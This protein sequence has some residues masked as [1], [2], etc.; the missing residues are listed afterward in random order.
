[1]GTKNFHLAR[2]RYLFKKCFGLFRVEK[3]ESLKFFTRTYCSSRKFNR[4]YLASQTHRFLLNTSV[5]T[6][7]ASQHHLFISYISPS[8]ANYRLIFSYVSYDFYVTFTFGGFH[9]NLA[10]VFVASFR[11]VDNL[12]LFS[13]YKF[14]YFCIHND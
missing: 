2:K 12:F 3:Y 4:L 1:M 9:T 11:C 6:K 7:V 5:E 10:S 14:Q 8:C 13:Q